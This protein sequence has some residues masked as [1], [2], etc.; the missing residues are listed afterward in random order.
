MSE[1][2]KCDLCDEP[3]SGETAEMYDPLAGNDQDSVVCHAQ[4]G[5][6]AGLEVA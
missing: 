6:S 4:C 2:T 5:L 1:T 3:L